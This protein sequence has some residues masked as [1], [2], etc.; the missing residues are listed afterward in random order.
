[1]LPK[2]L[3]LSWNGFERIG[4][5]APQSVL[6]LNLNCELGGLNI[7]NSKAKTRVNPSLFVLTFPFKKQRE[8][9]CRE[10]LLTPE[11]RS[12]G[13]QQHQALRDQ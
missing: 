8:D 6:R 4:S 3:K 5:L 1:M 13:K 11:C 10:R 7:D 2:T 12:E 9:S